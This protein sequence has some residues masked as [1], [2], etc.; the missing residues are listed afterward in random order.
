MVTIPGLRFLLP[1]CGY[2][3]FLFIKEQSFLV[4]NKTSFNFVGNN[5]CRSNTA[6]GKIKDKSLLFQ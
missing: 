1:F 6:Y 5:F 4:E 3:D 2:P